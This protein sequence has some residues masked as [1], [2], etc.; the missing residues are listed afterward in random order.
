MTSIPELNRSI[1]LLNEKKIDGLII[2]LDL[3]VNKYVTITQ[4]EVASA[5]IIADITK[6]LFEKIDSCPCNKDILEHIK[7]ISIIEQKT[8]PGKYSGLKK[9][10]PPNPSV[11][12]PDLGSSKNSQKIDIFRKEMTKINE[13]DTESKQEDNFKTNTKTVKFKYSDMEDDE[14]ESSYTAT[15]R[16]NK[17]KYEFKTP[18]HNGIPNSGQGPNTINVLNIDCIQDLKLRER[19]VDKWVTEISLI[20]QT[21]PDEF[22]KTKNV[23]LLLEHKTDGIVQKFL[24]NNNWNDELHGSDLFDNLINVI[25]TT[26]LGLDY[27]SNKDFTINKKVDIARVSMTKLQLHDISLLDKYTCMYESYLYDIPQRSEYA[28]WISAYLMKILIIGETCTDRWKKEATGEIQQPSL[29]YATK[30]AKEEIDR[31][32]QDIYKQQ[33]LKTISKDCCSILSDFKNFDIGKKNYT[34][35]MYKNKKK[36]KSFWKKKRRKFS[37][38]KYFKKPSKETP[39][40]TTSC[41]QGKKKCGCW[42]CNEEGHYTNEC[43]NRKKY[44]DKVMVLQTANNGGYEALEEE[45]D[46][47]GASLCLASKLIIPD[48]LWFKQ[49]EDLLEKV[50]SENPIDPNKTKGW[51]KASIKLIDPKTVIREKPMVYSL[52]DREEFSK[53]IKE[54]L[55]MRLI[56]ESKSPHMSPTFLVNK[57]AEKRRG[58]KC[59]VVNYKATNDA[60]IGD[61]HNL[62]YMHELLTLLRG[63]NI[64]SSFD[65]KSGFWQVL[66]DEEPQL[67]IA[68]TCLDGLFQW[69][70]LPFGLKQAP[71]IFQRHMQNAL[72]GLEGFCTVYVDDNMIFSKNEQEHY[73]HVTQVLRTILKYGIILSKKKAHLFKTKI[74]F[75]GLEINEGTHCPHKHILVHLHDFPN[76]LEDK[77]Q[78][79][80]FLGVLTYA[81]IEKLA[82]KRKPL[83]AKLKKDVIWNWS[84]ADTDYIKKIKKVL[85]NFPKLYLPNIEDSLIIE[86]DASNEFWEGVLKAKNP[87]NEEQICRYTSGSFKAAEKN[88]H[89][90][91]KEL[92][93]E[94]KTYWQTA[95]PVTSGISKMTTLSPS[96]KSVQEFTP[97]YK[98]ALNKEAERFYVIYKGPHVGV[99]TNWGIT[100][101]FCKVDKVTC[102]KFRNEAS[103]RLSLATYQDDTSKTNQPLLRPKIQKVKEAH[104]DQRFDV[105]NDIQQIVNYPE[106]S[107]EDF[108]TIWKKARAACP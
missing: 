3:T 28:Q 94:T 10:S 39:K 100:E 18:V 42:I 45:Y 61:S 104:R 89:S 25:Y 88:Y 47:T 52:Q 84:S 2:N 69:K 60:T 73:V 78:L 9:Y 40:K 44:P 72:R 53:Q 65:C 11:G 67:L 105:L 31:I 96:N 92:L 51:M 4:L 85:I 75:L 6:E 13:P 70:V 21:N 19:V 63:K 27:I 106:I 43:P 102:K 14:S 5:K 20:L 23:L 24:R 41:P 15:R 46:D 33:K 58:K 62:P 34:K 81:D 50:C 48:E 55:D 35:K 16:G 98:K 12:N 26:F 17:K 83:Q 87:K 80:K 38:G 1:N 103:A 97:D 91:E 22:E 54:L 30:I 74:I 57:E 66:L 99:H 64:Y 95:S 32:C 36:Y 82:A 108:R 77:K 93:A 79:Q 107:F 7:N 71:S 101:T 37:P 8:K 49:I 29:S 90:N 56:I 59:M 86:I 68:F 76:V